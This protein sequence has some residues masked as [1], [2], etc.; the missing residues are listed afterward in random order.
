[1]FLVYSDG[2]ETS[3][4]TPIGLLNRSLVFK[5]TKAAALLTATHGRAR[6]PE[7]LML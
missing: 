4:A 5:L 2:R 6:A 7:R 3:S 1:M